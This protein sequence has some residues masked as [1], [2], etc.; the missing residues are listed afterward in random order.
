MQFDNSMVFSNLKLRKL[1]L[2]QSETQHNM[3]VQSTRGKHILSMA[4]GCRLDVV[5]I[6]QCCS[7][8]GW[9]LDVNRNVKDLV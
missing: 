5:K 2:P 6:R 3:V 9:W 1:W 4:Y 7:G 8:L